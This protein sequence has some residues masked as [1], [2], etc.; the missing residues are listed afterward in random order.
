MPWLPTFSGD[1]IMFKPDTKSLAVS[2]GHIKE[3]DGAG[4]DDDVLM[5]TLRRANLDTKEFA[6]ANE[7][8]RKENDSLGKQLTR[9]LVENEKLKRKPKEFSPVFPGSWLH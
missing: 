4:F 3:T 8:L 2:I 1:L 9:L 7:L 5:V 6:D